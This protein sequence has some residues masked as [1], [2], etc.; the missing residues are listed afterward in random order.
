MNK[1]YQ[2][3][4]ASQLLQLRG[5]GTI[6]LPDRGLLLVA[7]LHLGKESTF[8]AGGIPVPDGPSASTLEGLSAAI[9]ETSCRQLIVLGDL[10]HN[11][12]SMTGS[13]VALVERWRAVH[14]DIEFRLVRGNHDRHVSRFPD[15]WQ[16]NDCEQWEIE[17]L[18]LVHQV[19]QT[20][21]PHPFCLEGHW[22]PVVKIGQGADRMRVRCFVLRPN[23]LTLP[24]FGPF[25]GGSL[26]SRSD[27]V[28][29]PILA[30]HILRT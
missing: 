29:F 11:R 24:S 6:F 4:V 7:D 15:S 2:L 14:R 10:I 5:D 30:G 18:T 22:H 9:A 25:K 28:V 3:N 12:D 26:V 16:L 8:R 13:L 27:A 21:P 20:D 1:E 19:D 17:G 23:R